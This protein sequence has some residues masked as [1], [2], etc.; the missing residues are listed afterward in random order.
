MSGVPPEARRWLVFLVVGIYLFAAWAPF[1]FQLPRRVTNDVV[2]NTDGSVMFPGD[3]MLRSRGP[4]PFLPDAI[5]RR[6]LRVT[7]QVQVPSQP[8]SAP[9]RALPA[10]IFDV[11]SDQYHS[12]ITVAQERRDLVVRV[13]RTSAS[14]SGGPPLVAS[15]AL[16]PRRWHT[17]VVSVGGGEIVVELN[18]RRVAGG[19][20]P[21]RAFD[22]WDEGHRVSLGNEPAGARPWQ[23]RVR[24]ARVQVDG[25]ATD[26]LRPGVLARPARWWSLPWRGRTVEMG[27]DPLDVALN[28]AAFVPLGYLAADRRMRHRLV[29]AVGAGTAVSATM[30]VGQLF[31]PLR[32]PSI[33]DFFLNVAGAL[34]GGLAVVY[35]RMRVHAGPDAPS[36]TVR[37]DEGH[38]D[39]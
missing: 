34:A 10:R 1:H 39:G 30:E 38:R 2:R 9:N 5:E 31:L 32:S 27:I 29:A 26:L 7:L 4:A 25:R 14:P 17:I 11:A 37:P 19:R 16:Q 35:L 28:F 21:D 12:N 36:H 22:L 3:G 23:G 24:V 6:R 13:R 15:L 33:T 20:M 8:Q 18:G